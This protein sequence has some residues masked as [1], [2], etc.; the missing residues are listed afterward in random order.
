M[1]LRDI[2][3][4]KRNEMNFAGD[5]VRGACHRISVEFESACGE[6]ITQ[7][8]KAFA[9]PLNLDVFYYNS[10]SIGHILVRHFAVLATPLQRYTSQFIRFLFLLFLVVIMCIYFRFYYLLLLFAMYSFLIILYC[11]YCDAKQSMLRAN[12]RISL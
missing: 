2:G 1:C 4:L 9:F 10:F 11:C 12:F 7:N 8:G 3:A 6:S 5:S